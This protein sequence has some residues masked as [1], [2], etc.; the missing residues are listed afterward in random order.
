ML[1]FIYV[2]KVV[3]RC[4]SLS[5]NPLPTMDLHFVTN[6]L[7]AEGSDDTRGKGYVE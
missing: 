1:P 2:M 5:S 7:L 4:R 6:R 3:R